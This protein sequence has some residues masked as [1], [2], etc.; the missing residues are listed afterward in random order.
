MI[1]GDAWRS[2][3]HVTPSPKP[4][5]WGFDDPHMVALLCAAKALCA[6]AYNCPCSWEDHSCVPL[7]YIAHTQSERRWRLKRVP[8]R[9]HASTR[10]L[11][12]LSLTQ[13]RTK[14][15]Q[16]PRRE[17]RA[18]MPLTSKGRKK[19]KKFNIDVVPCAI[20]CHA[21]SWFASKL[22]RLSFHSNVLRRAV[23]RDERTS[24]T[25]RRCP[26]DMT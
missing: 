24:R 21:A 15:G 26:H 2:S 1:L 8:T 20:E 17:V 10:T 4:T 11:T 14:H 16:T 12:S 5:R 18:S 6:S 7:R 25:P 23:K 19:S 3:G 13:S 22:D 9:L